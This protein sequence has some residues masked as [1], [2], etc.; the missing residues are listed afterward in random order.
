M[1]PRS[2]GVK[3]EQVQQAAPRANKRQKI[4]ITSLDH[5]AVYKFL[6]MSK[7]LKDAQSTEALLD[8]ILPGAMLTDVRTASLSKDYQ[9]FCKAKLQRL[10][11]RKI[12]LQKSEAQTVLPCPKEEDTEAHEADTSEQVKE[13]SEKPEDVPTVFEDADLNVRCQ[14]SAHEYGL[15]DLWEISDDD[16]QGFDEELSDDDLDERIRAL[17]L[18][19]GHEERT[20]SDQH[21]DNLHEEA[22]Y[23]QNNFHRDG[24]VPSPEPSDETSHDTPAPAPFGLEFFTD[25]HNSYNMHN[26]DDVQSLHIPRH[27]SAYETMAKGACERTDP[28]LQGLIDLER[29]Q[30]LY[31]D[32]DAEYHV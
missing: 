8:A 27:S 1:K 7:R 22:R 20:K 13:E 5:A 17:E 23:A 11:E 4:E 10:R 12:A 9:T 2:T 21:S 29:E 28:L 6:T 30:E 14:S 19:F 15:D 26:L 24:S 25:H 31:G 3:I 18:Q 32:F 16:M